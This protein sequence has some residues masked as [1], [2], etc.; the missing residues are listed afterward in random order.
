MVD[1]ANATAPAKSVSA[2]PPAAPIPLARLLLTCMGF[3]VALGAWIGLSE[4]NRLIGQVAVAGSAFDATSVYGPGTVARPWAWT[5]ALPAI[6][7]WRAGWASRGS[8]FTIIDGLQAHL[9]FDLIFIAGYTLALLALLPKVDWARPARRLVI[10][11]AAVDVIEDGLAWLVLPRLIVQPAG[12]GADGWLGVLHSVTVLKWLTILALLVALVQIG[13]TRS[14]VREGARR[15]AVGLKFQRYPLVVVAVL[16]LFFVTTSGEVGDQLPDVQRAW[17]DAPTGWVHAL[18]AGAAIALVAAGTLYL[19][20]RRAYRYAE[21]V[22]AVPKVRAGTRQPEDGDGR[23]PSKYGGWIAAGSAAYAIGVGGWASEHGQSVWLAIIFGLLPIAVLAALFVWRRTLLPFSGK[24]WLTLLVGVGAWLLAP[25]TF[26]LGVTIS[27]ARFATVVTIPSVLLTASAVLEDKRGDRDWMTVRLNRNRDEPGY[28][29]VVRTGEAITAAVVTVTGVGLIR[30]FT[31]PA[32]ILGSSN[33]AAGVVLGFVLAAAMWP[34]L[35]RP[36]HLA[37]TRAVENVPTPTDQ[38][39]LF[40]A[41]GSLW[42]WLGAAALAVNWVL[43]VWLLVNPITVTSALG[44]VATV[45]V[46]VGALTSLLGLAALATQRTLPWAVFRPFKLQ[47][48]PV[49]SILIVI[50][51]VAASVATLDVHHDVAS[52]PPP[53]GTPTPAQRPDLRA[54]FTGW[55]ADRASVQERCGM[56]V[57]VPARAG[58]GPRPVRAT[59][60]VLV[61]AAGGG[62]RAAWWTVNGLTTLGD[63]MGDCARAAILASSGVSGGSVG[64]AIADRAPDP[65][66]AVG[67]IASPD[68]LSSAVTGLLQT[69][70]LSGMTGINLPPVGW[71]ARQ[72]A[73]RAA[74]MQQT[75]EHNIPQLTQSFLAP[76]SGAAGQLL[77]NST[78]VTS[79]CRALVATM[80]VAANPAPAPQ[81]AQAHEQPATADSPDCTALTASD[82]GLLPDSYDLLTAYTNPSPR[83]GNVLADCRQA[84]SVA[85][86]AMLSARFPYVT[87][88]GVMPACNGLAADQ[89]VDGGYAEDTSLGTVADLAPAVM[90]LVRDHNARVLAGTATDPGAQLLVVPYVLWLEN[91]FRLDIRQPHPSGE[92]E[93]LAPIQ[94]QAA[95]AQMGDATALLQRLTAAL[96]DWS[97]CAADDPSCPTAVQGINAA[98][99]ARTI[100]VAPNSAPRVEAPLGWVLSQTSQQ[101]LEQSLIDAR[102]ACAPTAEP[103]CPSG[104]G[105]LDDLRA[106]LRGLPAG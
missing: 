47:A 22:W 7:V 66:A 41:R 102:R 34:L 30:S 28:V 3:S 75:W 18:A 1:T 90:A 80:A 93:L 40:V 43:A 26:A 97:S 13:V 2:P 57:T 60:L 46:A 79:K 82:T 76:G 105:H 94:T 11:V 12:S 88:T 49:L 52:T 83:A 70:L 55:L 84:L 20:R 21:L 15:V 38:P 16:A 86:A 71:P 59:P 103:G 29:V 4:A 17:L 25:L 89:F 54:A 65:T 96:Q 95:A 104:V 68:A 99:P 9:M 67:A 73:D 92:P 62:I 61:A 72:P 39:T 53:A 45:M 98:W 85:T 6:E 31:A 44:V 32:I 14:S 35:W 100:I 24:A 27:W 58:T 36:R 77:L 33:A 23:S 101:S 87:P 51:V 37:A 19:S 91:H 10:A 81:A 42:W 64:L 50:G 63:D 8:G 48:T 69:D 74:F 56:P 78:S 106:S 5:S